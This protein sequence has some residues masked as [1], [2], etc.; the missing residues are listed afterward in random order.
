MARRSTKEIVLR[1]LDE[2]VHEAYEETG[3][4]GPASNAACAS[5]SRNLRC[6]RAGL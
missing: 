2:M 5:G 3:R 1:V 6:V 4:E